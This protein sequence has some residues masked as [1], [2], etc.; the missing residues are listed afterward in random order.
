MWGA[1]Y[2]YSL[3]SHQTLDYANHKYGAPAKNGMTSTL[4]M[5][6]IPDKVESPASKP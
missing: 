6:A 4:V 1:W 2:V 3:L 5:Y